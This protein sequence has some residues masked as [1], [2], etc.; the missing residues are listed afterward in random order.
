MHTI[1]KRL[2]G[3]SLGNFTDVLG[4]LAVGQEHELL[5]EFVGILGHMDMYTSGLTLLVNVKLNLLAVERHRSTL[6]EA[7]TAQLLSHLIEHGQL[8]G[9]VALARFQD[10]LSLLIGEA[11]V[12]AGDGVANFVFLHLGL[13]IHL[14]NDRV[15]KFILIGAERTDE[16]TQL[17]GEHGHRAIHQIDRRGTLIS[18]LVNDG[19]RGDIVAHIGDVNANLPVAV[20]EFFYRKSVVKVLGIGGVNRE[21]SH[22]A[23]VTTTGNLLGSNSR[24]Q[25]FG[26]LGHIL[27]ILIWQAKLGENGMN[28]GIVFASNTQNV[29][30]LTDGAVGILGPLHNFHHRLVA[31]FAASEFVKRDKDV[32]SQELAVSGQLGEIFHHLQGTDKHL[33]LALQDFHHLGLRLHAMASGADVYQ[34]TVTVQSVHRVALSN[35][36]GVSIVAGRVNAVLAIAA[37]NKDALGNR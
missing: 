8:L 16:V 35:H 30:D 37:A 24:I 23:H 25:E 1:Y 19:A 31:G 2:G 32:G 27:G 3:L 7:A 22:V 13:G 9:Q 20:F 34:Y 33:F 12:A 5:D 10:V 36:D 28:L 11:P 21:G 29:D 4:H 17:L 14:H 15:G 18:L 6:L 26:G